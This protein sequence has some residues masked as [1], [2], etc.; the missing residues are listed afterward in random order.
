MLVQQQP[1][2]QADT[3]CTTEGITRILPGEGFEVSDGCLGFVS[4]MLRELAGGLLACRTV[5]CSVCLPDRGFAQLCNRLLDGT[6]LLLQMAKLRRRIVSGRHAWGDR[7]PCCIHGR[8]SFD[9][10][11]A[12]EVRHAD[13]VRD[14]RCVNSAEISRRSPTGYWRVAY[15]LRIRRDRASAPDADDGLAEQ[16]HSKQDDQ[17]R[18]QRPR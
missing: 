13:P 1:Q 5:A 9:G 8:I 16:D 17:Y 11:N 3:E 14:L 6:E 10:S 2:R 18:R 4:G 7:L 15:R 12:L